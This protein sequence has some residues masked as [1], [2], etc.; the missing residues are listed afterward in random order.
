VPVYLSAAAPPH[1]LGEQMA[2]NEN[3][4]KSVPREEGEIFWRATF[5][6]LAVLVLGISSVAALALLTL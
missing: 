4:R 3:T 2:S 1:I 5:A 6:L